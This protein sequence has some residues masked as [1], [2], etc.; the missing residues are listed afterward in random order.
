MK[1]NICQSENEDKQKYCGNCGVLLGVPPPI[2]DEVL[3]N[4]IEAFIKSR[5]K[6]QQLLEYQTSEN[7]A[8]KLNAWAK[9]LL[10]FVAIPLAIFGFILTFLGYNSYSKFSS[11]IDETKTSLDKKISYA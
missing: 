8:T 4:K 2:S 3:G 7:I 10:F 1:C 9:L 11:L 5:Y 6:E